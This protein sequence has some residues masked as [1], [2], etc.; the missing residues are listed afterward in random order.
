MH[1]V[2]TETLDGYTIKIY[3]DEDPINPRVDMETRSKMICFHRRY[4]LGDA[5]NF[6]SPSA[7]EEWLKRNKDKIALVKPLYLYDHSGI[8]ISTVP[9]S[10]PWD[11]GQVGV[12]YVLKQDNEEVDAEQIIESEVKLYDQFLT[13]EVYGFRI[14]QGVEDDAEEVDSCWGFYGMDHCLEEAQSIVQ[15]R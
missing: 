9:F 6:D 2:H 3:R 5:H 1:S 13:G 7:A 14:F 8:T 4:N 12:V 15:T 10:C 11:S